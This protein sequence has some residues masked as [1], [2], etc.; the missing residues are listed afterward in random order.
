MIHG[1]V[2]T[3]LV[4]IAIYNYMS[5][6]LYSNMRAFCPYFFLIPLPERIQISFFGRDNSINGTMILIWIQMFVL[7]SRIVQH[8][9]LH[10]CVCSISFGRGSDTYPII[11]AGGEFKL[12]A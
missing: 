2:L 6:E 12:K 10:T 9:D 5:V 3:G 7:R 8:L 1:A 11:G 4:N